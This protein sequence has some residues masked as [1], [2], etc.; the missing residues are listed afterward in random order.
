VDYVEPVQAIIPGVQGRVL[1]ALVKTDAELSM[2]SVAKLAGASVN[3][4]VTVVNRLVDLGVV[5]RRDVGSTAL[6]RID[7]ENEAA[8]AILLIDAIRD[9]VIRRLR[10]AAA[11]IKPTPATLMVFGSFAR[12]EARPGSDL[13]VLAVRPRAVDVEDQSW[14][15]SLASWTELATRISG[16]PVALLTADFDEIASL[17][18]RPNTVWTS[19]AAEGILLAG[20]PLRE[21]GPRVET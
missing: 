5:Q 21:L 14:H 2:R 7:R 3:R 16:N 4:A 12:G 13:D 10:D 19:A 1:A 9:S 15:D 17:L 20:Q 11:T 6:V 8:Q 18:T